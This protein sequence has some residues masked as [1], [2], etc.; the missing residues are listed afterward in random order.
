MAQEATRTQPFRFLFVL[1]RR[2]VLPGMEIGMTGMCEGEQR[3][4][5]I[6]PEEYFN[7]DGELVEP[8]E[9]CQG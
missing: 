6:P 2:Q 4:I 9:V 8:D 3:R 7:D 5:I 1:G